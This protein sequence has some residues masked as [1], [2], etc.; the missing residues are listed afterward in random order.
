MFGTIVQSM[1]QGLYR[2]WCVFSVVLSVCLIC[3]D[4][5]WPFSISF[6]LNHL[7]ILWAQITILIK[8]VDYILKFLSAVLSN[9]SII[10]TVLRCLI[11]PLLSGRQHVSEITEV[12]HPLVRAEHNLLLPLDIDRCPFSHYIKSVLKVSQAGALSHTGHKSM[13]F[14]DIKYSWNRMGKHDVI[15]YCIINT[16]LDRDLSQILFQ[17]CVQ[18]KT[19]KQWNYYLFQLS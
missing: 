7:N 16:H 3:N 12:A 13:T 19:I 18:N 4:F 8:S 14:T 15:I 10:C 11:L 1:K 6:F 5:R 17:V 2:I 9:K